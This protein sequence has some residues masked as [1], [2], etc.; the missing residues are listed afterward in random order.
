MKNCPN[1]CGK[2]IV[3]D[4]KSYC[5]KCGYSFANSK[6]KKTVAN[7]YTQA[8]NQQIKEMLV[9]AKLTGEPLPW[10]RE[11]VIIPKRNF[12]SNRQYTGIN[13]WLLSFDNSIC[14]LTEKSIQKHGGTLKED[15]TPR[16]VVAWIPARLKEE[17]K[18][19]SE[20]EQKAILKKRFPFMVT[21][22]VYRSID[23]E[24]LPEKTFETD[25]ENE[26]NLTVEEFIQSIKDTKGLVFEEGGNQ[27]RYNY[28][29]DIVS[30]PRIE[31]YENSDAYYRDLFHEI[32]HWTAHKDRLSRDEKKYQRKES[33]GR[34]ELIAE[35]GAAYLCHYFGIPVTE[36]TGAYIDNWLTAIEGDANLLVSA[37]QQA[38]KVLKYFE[39]AE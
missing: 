19:L 15:A 10:E 31:Q 14:Y 8:V 7:K 29:T 32:V 22:F 21:N 38:E 20:A 28:T 33:Y 16:I 34:E 12:D 5:E 37:G 13:R 23:V 18:K 26:R 35:M 2:L 1:N 17:E 39:L 9:E 27:P 6:P 24:G 30:V 36:N 3:T 25:R 11:W 4:E